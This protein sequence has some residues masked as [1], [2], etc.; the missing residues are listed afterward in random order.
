MATKSLLTLEDY[1]RLSDEE[2]RLYELD[3]GEL[4]AR[5]G[6]GMTA[7]RFGHNAVRDTLLYLIRD[8]LRTRDAGRVVAE[9][10]F[11]LGPA[12]V[13]QPDVAFV[14]KERANLLDPETAILDGAPD[15][16]IGVVSD[17]DTA[18]GLERKV[19]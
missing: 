2:S 7:A 19:D 1:E 17:S 6:E 3:D 16:A 15:L 13:R 9:Q 12:T 14:R 8:Y 4:V 5:F 10:H 18:E 11:R